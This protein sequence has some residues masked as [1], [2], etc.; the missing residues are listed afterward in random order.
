MV[1]IKHLAAY[2]QYNLKIL[3]PDNK[4]TLTLK[5]LNGN[6]LILDEDGVEKYGHIKK[7]KFVLRPISD[8]L[9]EI[10][11]DGIKVTPIFEIIKLCFSDFIDEDRL[12]IGEINGDEVNLTIDDKSYQFSFWKPFKSFVCCNQETDE[13]LS[14]FNQHEIFELCYRLKIDIHNLISDGS[15]VNFNSI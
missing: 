10:E 4:T 14:V 1:K 13:H 9:K 15:A 5:G 2:L 11:I 3:R 12:A 7:N 8:L 6:L